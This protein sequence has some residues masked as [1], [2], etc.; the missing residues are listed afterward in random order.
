[1]LPPLRRLLP[2]G[3]NKAVAVE[4]DALP[5]AVLEFQSP[6]A[7]IIAMPIPRIAR[8]TNLIIST[9][10]L[11]MITM[12][13]VLKT[14]RIVSAPGELDST[15]SDISVQAFNAQS[16]VRALNVHQGEVVKAGQVLATIDPTYTAADLTSLTQ[17]E[18]NYAAQ[19]AELQALENNQPYLADPSNPYSVLAAQT[20]NQQ[21][22][23]YHA[24]MDN[25][26]QQISQ[27]QQEIDGYH[28]QQTYYSQRLAI[29]SN[30][31]T[32]RKKLQQLQVGSQLDTEAATDS[33]VTV[34]A[35][36][37]SAASS[38]SAS[39]KQL[40]SVQAQRDG[41]AQ[42]FRGQISA[43]LATALNDLS[44]AKQALAK[45]QLNG[46]LVDLVSPQDA[47]V[48]S[49]AP[50]AIGS[51]LNAG[52]QVFDLAPINAPFVVTANIDAKES[53]YV[54]VGNQVVI[55]FDT[56]ASMQYGTAKGTVISVSPE[57]INP[58][59]QQQVAMSG[60]PI[61]GTPPNT[62]YYT[63][64][65]SVD[66]LNLHNLP[67]GFRLMPGMPVEADLVVGRRTIIEYFLQRIVPVAYNAMREP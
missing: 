51:V 25:Y 45:A 42:Q 1:M 17:Q 57:S 12:A 2:K 41:F 19:V 59:D 20:Y 55:S 65:I 28:Q 6:T 5:L 13:C 64:Q 10:V 9:M 14:E 44:Q 38:A 46:E 50:I 52:Q 56:L 31:E 62:L 18:Q 30:V 43:Q 22:G 16:I 60:P 26:T 34:Q 24:S 4:P 7:A 61:P 49:V 67:D 40:A 15:E 3:I 23:T 36:L 35:Q 8:S 11:L 53:G 33:R 66:E 63:A 21:M 58:N 39:E 48:Q 54:H 29:A 37:S 47:V 27:L 32:M